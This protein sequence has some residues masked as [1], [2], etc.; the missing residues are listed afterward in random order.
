MREKILV[1]VFLYVPLQ[2]DLA[3]TICS[4]CCLLSN[5]CFLSL[6]KIQ[7]TMG[8]SFTFLWSTCLFSHQHMLLISLRLCSILEFRDGDK[9]RA[10]FIVQYCFGC[11]EYFI[12]IWILRLLFKFLWR[13]ALKSWLL[14]PWITFKK[15]T[16]HTEINLRKGK[17]CTLKI[18]KPWKMKL[19]KIQEK[20]MT[21]HNPRWIESML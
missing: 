5:V 3:S 8:F 14:T 19:K 18:L 4:R 20:G 17:T 1:S 2:L 21:S 15:K 16:K 11:P 6:W 7:V 10:L 9:F 13:I 12:S